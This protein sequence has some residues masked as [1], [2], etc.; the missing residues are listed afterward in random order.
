MSHTFLT[1]A[2]RVAL[3]EASDLIAKRRDASI[4]WTRVHAIINQSTC[5]NDRVS[6]VDQRAHL[7]THGIAKGLPIV[8]GRLEWSLI[9]GSP[10]RHA[11]LSGASDFH[12][13]DGT[14]ILIAQTTIA[15]QAKRDRAIEIIQLTWISIGRP[16]HFMEEHRDRGPIEPRSRR[17]WTAIAARSSRDNAPFVVESPQRSSYGGRWSINTTIDARSWPDRGEN[18]GYSEVKLKPNSPP[19]WSGIEATTSP[20]GT[21][22]TTPLIS[23]HDRLYRPWIWANFPFKKPCILPL[24]FNFWSIHEEINRILRNV[25]SSRDPLLQRV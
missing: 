25:L 10:W 21:A 4:V 23:P 20:Q 11:E 9:Y 7:M 22:P 24:F 2:G 14:M 6:E 16:R 17:N 15:H 1:C 13:A 3:R 8:I 18:R 12:H 5:G 19:N